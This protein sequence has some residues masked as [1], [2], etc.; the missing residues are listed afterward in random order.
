MRGPCAGYPFAC[1]CCCPAHFLRLPLLLPPAHFLRFLLLCTLWEKP[2][3]LSLERSQPTSHLFSH[4]SQ[5][6]NLVL[7]RE[8]PE[9]LIFESLTLIVTPRPQQRPPP[10]RCI[11]HCTIPSASAT[12][13]YH[14]GMIHTAA[15]HCVLMLH[16]AAARILL[17]L[18]SYYCWLPSHCYWPSHTATVLVLPT[19]MQHSASLPLCHSPALPLL[20]ECAAAAATASLCLRSLWRTGQRAQLAAYKNSSQFCAA[21]SLLHLSGRLL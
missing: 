13:Y 7:Y 10:C 3:I 12:A 18:P 21:H 9:E 6:S 8:L 11:S 14:F 4:R 1:H 16:A 5:P 17:L 2:Q 19:L 20:S 15:A